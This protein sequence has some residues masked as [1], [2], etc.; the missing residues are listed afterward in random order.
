M[1]RC[2]YCD[3]FILFGG[4]KQ[5]GR[6]FC[7]DSCLQ[8]GRLMIA[9]DRLPQHVVDD[10]VDEAHQSSCPLCNGPGPIDV[11]TS[12]TIW[13]LIALTSWRSTPHVCCRSCGR[14]KQ[15]MGFVTSGLFGWWGF[16]WGVIYTPIQIG[17]NLSGMLGGPDADVPSEQ[18]ELLTRLDIAARVDAGE[19]MPRGRKRPQKPQ[20]PEAADDRIPVECDDCGKRFKAKAMMAGKSGKCPGCGS[21]ITVPETDKWLEDNYGDEEWNDDAYGNYGNDG[22]YDDGWG[23][24]SGSAKSR[25]KRQP[26]KKTWTPL[27]IG[28]VVVAGFVGL[29][30]VGIIVAAVIGI[31]ADDPRP[32]FGQNNPPVIPDLER[33]NMEPH[34]FQN[35]NAAASADPDPSNGLTAKQGTEAVATGNP[36][37][38][39]QAPRENAQLTADGQSELAIAA[40]EPLA[41]VDP[42]A[43]LW[44]VL[45]NF[46]KA[47]KQGFGSINRRFLIDYQIAAGSVSPNEKYVL[48]VSKSL[49]GGTFKQF[50]DTAVQLSSSGTIEFGL[51]PALGIGNDFVASIAIPDGGRKWKYVSGELAPNGPKTAA[52]RPPTIRELAGAAAQGKTLAIANPVFESGTGPFPTLTVPFELQQQIDV[53][54]YYM[55]VAESPSGERVELDIKIS[56]QRVSVGTESQFAARLVGGA[57]TLKPPFT[58]YVEKRKMRFSSPVRPE[59]PEVVS[60]KV[61]VAG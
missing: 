37:D 17:K 34:R 49:A 61:S 2:D 10:A 50:A 38:T 14:Q 23:D 55:L 18:L 33:P 15:L 29:N 24:S 7:N 36:S 27:R 1:A 32:Q 3:S 51:S 22:G 46:R 47:S 26:K 41:N 8:E 30:I 45:S 54:Q 52:E 53:S 4:K 21:S 48:H 57:R 35:P 44:V 56:L 60:N 9:A 42:S 13:S 16:P 58:L 19:P 43:K 59:T 39:A 20:P 5:S 12:H 31:F 25:R 6:T 28:L 11:H 40:V